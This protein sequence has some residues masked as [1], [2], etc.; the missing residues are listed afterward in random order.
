MSGNVAHAPRQLF[1]MAFS[2][3]QGGVLPVSAVVVGVRQS[4]RTLSQ[5]GQQYKSEPW[6]SGNPLGAWPRTHP[7]T[8]FA[9]T[10]I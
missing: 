4:P 2:A 9:G 10:L 1:Y 7:C 3:G 6:L 5:Y 8:A